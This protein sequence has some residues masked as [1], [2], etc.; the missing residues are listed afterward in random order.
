VPGAPPLIIGHRGASAVA[1]ENTLAA[2]AQAVRDGA[3]G[4]EFDVRLSRDRVPVVIHDATLSRTATI[5]RQVADL[6]SQELHKLDVGS[7][8]NS[9]FSD[10]ARQEYR[11]EKLPTLKSVFDFFS[12]SPGLLYV[13]M[14]CEGSA[15][16]ALARE[17]VDLIHSFSFC[18]RAIVECFD[19][20]ALGQVKRLDSRIRTAALFE[21]RFKQ[22]TSFVKRMAMVDKALD[23][24][25]DEIALHHTLVTQRIVDRARQINMPCVVW[26]VDHPRWVG[27]A[28]SLGLKALMTNNPEAMVRAI[29]EN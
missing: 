24:G 13:E 1:P 15:C 5:S 16:E 12:S 22:A 29:L 28:A 2:F 25:A 27:R 19:L 14:K 11:G 4:I 23:C 26:T 9:K 20:M 17:L 18:E 3:D 10:L 21:P 7:W 6:T 8:F